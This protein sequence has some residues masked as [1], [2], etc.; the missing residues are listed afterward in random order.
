MSK[1]ETK[2]AGISPGANE[3]AVRLPREAAEALHS[4]VN[5]G[6]P[7][8][9]DMKEALSLTL[10]DAFDARGDKS[11]VEADDGEVVVLIPKGGLSMARKSLS[12][13]GDMDHGTKTDLG[14]RLA[15]A[16]R[17]GQTAEKDTDA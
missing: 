15:V 14:R 12:G 5:A 7:L 9:A 16:I 11:A 2:A 6:T 10:G 8:E 1:N 4:H 13:E 3:I 17:Q